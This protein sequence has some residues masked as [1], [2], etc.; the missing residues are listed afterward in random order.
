M[1]LPATPH[2]PP[3][4]AATLGCLRQAALLAARSAQHAAHAT[5]SRGP[6][7]TSCTNWG[8][9]ARRSTQAATTGAPA[10]EEH[11]PT[12]HFCARRYWRLCTWLEGARNCTA[13][14]PAGAPASRLAAFALSSRGATCWVRDPY[15]AC[16][17]HAW[18]RRHL[19]AT[20]WSRLRRLGLLAQS[21][22]AF[23]P[24]PAQA[25]SPVGLKQLHAHPHCHFPAPL[26]N[27]HVLDHSCTA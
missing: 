21:V 8:A 14:W 18:G 9:A 26:S 25:P 4:A 11:L 23:A 19:R 7:P 3:S 6:Q 5:S 15:G 17:G 12:W 10:S 1:P 27:R 24:P 22:K 13:F 16:M 2:Q 20:V